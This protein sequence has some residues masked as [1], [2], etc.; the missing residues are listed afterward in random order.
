MIQ[1]IL[2]ENGFTEKQAAVYLAVLAAG[3]APVSRIAHAA[4]IARP[5]VYTILADL[6]AQGIVTTT[7]RKGI[8]YASALPPRVLIDRFKR[9]AAEAEAALPQ[10]LEMA[11]SSP[12]KPRIQFFETMEGLQEILRDF[13]YAKDDTMFFS[14]YASMPPALYRFLWKGDHSRTQATSQLWSRTVTT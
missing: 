10:L 1:S 3:E 2:T 5:T 9:S 13:S 4:K 8:V 11:Y 14:D 6:K 7:T 12:L